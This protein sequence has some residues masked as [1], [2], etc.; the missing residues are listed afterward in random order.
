MSDATAVGL[1]LVTIGSMVASWILF[2]DGVW[3]IGGGCFGFCVGV[4]VAVV[5]MGLERTKR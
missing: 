1:F 5:A 3:T 4:V 2:A